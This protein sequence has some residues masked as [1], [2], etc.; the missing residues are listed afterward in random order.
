MAVK[1][2]HLT[3]PPPDVRRAPLGNARSIDDRTRSRIL[4]LCQDG[5]IRASDR[6]VIDGVPNQEPIRVTL[7]WHGS[8]MV[9]QWFVAE[10]LRAITLLLRGVNETEDEAA[11]SAVTRIMM[12]PG[13]KVVEKMLGQL[14][15]QIRPEP[16]PAVATIHLT[17]MSYDNPLFQVCASCLAT[18]FFE[19]NF[20]QSR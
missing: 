11:I 4:G 19:Q 8:A 2:N 10:D 6:I 9:V 7:H 14:M 17:E 12:I 16:R 13:N 5:L 15:N 18:V 3:I 1:F 20:V